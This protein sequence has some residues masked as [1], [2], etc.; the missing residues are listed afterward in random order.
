MIVR[1]DLLHNLDNL[2]R[3]FEARVAVRYGEFFPSKPGR[4]AIPEI[5]LLCPLSV[6]GGRYRRHDPDG[7]LS[8]GHRKLAAGGALP[9]ALAQG[10]RT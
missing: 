5:R 7:A 9:G 10:L 3:V 1:N 8:A 2:E 4:S 6:A